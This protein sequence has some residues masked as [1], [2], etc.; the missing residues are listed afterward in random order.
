MG[1]F[2][3][4]VCSSE[5][6]VKFTNQGKPKESEVRTPQD[7]EFMKLEDLDMA[8]GSWRPNGQ[9]FDRSPDT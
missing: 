6:P 8:S 9:T 3:T 4:L 7:R 1:A 5:R 2:L